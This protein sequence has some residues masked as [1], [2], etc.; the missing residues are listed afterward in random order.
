MPLRAKAIGEGRYQIDGTVEGERVRR[1]IECRNQREADEKAFQIET[2]YRRQ[3]I[4]G[5]EVV[6]TFHHA[7]ARYVEEGGEGRF[8]PPLMERFK[9][10]KAIK[11]ITGADIRAAAKA[12]YPKAAPATWNRQV[13]APA[14]AVINF[15]HGYG[16]CNP[17]RVKTFTVKRVERPYADID[18]LMAFRAHATSSEIAALALFMFS[19][20]ARIGEAIKL[21][22][23]DVDLQAGTALLRDTKN[24]DDRVVLLPKALIFELEHLIGQK[25]DGNFQPINNHIFGFT[26]KQGHRKQWDRTIK[27]ARIERLTA[28]EAGRHAFG[29]FAHDTL[30]SSLDAAQAGGWKSR[31]LF[32][33]TYAHAGGK[34]GAIAL[35]IDEAMKPKIRRVK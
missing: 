5:P 23:D 32:E 27:A 8:L 14:S 31:Q 26:D 30:A 3:L 9:K 21:R 15:A 11:L 28:H 34:G 13:I 24:G 1:R 20:G 25:S 18:W 17:I 10:V 16:W 12:I 4:H 2:E 19:T 7:A 22:P 29:K 6:V 35:A 33:T